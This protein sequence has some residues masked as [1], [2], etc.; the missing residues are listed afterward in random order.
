MRVTSSTIV[1]RYVRNL[2]S[3]LTK[4]NGYENQIASGMQFTRASQNPI[5]ASRAL[6]VRKALAELSDYKDNLETSKSIYETAESAVMNVSN[7]IKNCYEQ[8]IYGANGTQGDNEDEILASSLEKLAEEMVQSMNVVVADRRIF[9]GTNNTGMA[10][11]IEDSASGKVVKYNGVSVNT[12]QDASMFPY[13]TTSYSDIGIGMSKLGDGSI[14]PQ[15]AL[16]VTFNGAE[17]MGCG[18]DKKI[19]TLDLENM[20]GDYSFDV[21]VGNVKKTIAFSAGSDAE[22]TADNINEALEA[23]FGNSNITVASNGVVSNNM[24]SGESVTVENTPLLDPGNANYV[25]YSQADIQVTP[26]GYSNNIIQLVFDAAAC[27]RSG[28]KLGAAKYADALFG[29]QTNLTLTI[30]NIGNNEDFIDFT[31]D[32]LTNNQYSL[33]ERQNTLEAYEPE[34]A[35]T[36]WKVMDAIYNATLQMSASVVPMSIF[37]FM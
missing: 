13:S 23:V 2:E 35:I 25:D 34:T 24:L 14:D 8:L 28:D 15:S 19:T 1:R 16:P 29:A 9:G 3:N 36:N 6:K 21:T 12:Y 18:L 33:Y 31:L 22:S 7:I 32:R 27:L 37:N 26:T 20:T 5:N 17:I 4:K 30:A 11:A 10:F